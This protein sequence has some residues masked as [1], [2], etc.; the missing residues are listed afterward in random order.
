MKKYIST[1]HLLKSMIIRLFILCS[2]FQIISMASLFGFKSE[3]SHSFSIISNAMAELPEEKSLCLGDKCGAG[4]L[5]LPSGKTVYPDEPTSVSEAADKAKYEDIEKS[6]KD[7]IGTTAVSSSKLADLIKTAAALFG[8]EV[9]VNYDKKG[10][11]SCFTL[12]SSG[13]LNVVSCS[14][15]GSLIS[16]CDATAAADWKS[17]TISCTGFELKATVVE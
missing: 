17:A 2:F 7:S 15:S 1:G 6:V 5:H 3:S 12:D 9:K 13:A 11:L 16:S 4:S 10:G 8:V 14:G